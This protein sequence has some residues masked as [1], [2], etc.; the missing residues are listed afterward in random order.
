MRIRLALLVALASIVPAG[1]GAHHFAPIQPGS[2]MVE[3]AGCTMN[4]LF[5]DDAGNQY[6]GTA[7]HCVGFSSGVDVELSGTGKIGSVAWVARHPA[8][9]ALVRIDPSMYGLVNP[10][11]RYWGGPTGLAVYAEIAPGTAVYQYGHG[12]LLGSNEISRARAGTVTVPTAC[13]Y[14]A[15]L[16]VL[17]G[18]SG[19]PTMIGDGRALG[20]ATHIPG[21]FLHS[22]T[23]VECA[24]AQ[25]AAQGL[26]L[27]LR[28]APLADAVARELDRVDHL[29]P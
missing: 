12:L 17:F 16:P 3:P 23:R 18:D 8:D 21:L 4:F 14:H 1:A 27:T 20:V 15:N 29:T 22:G 5:A 25:A 24:L 7:G 28:T 9:F 26:R 19:S 2:R 13:R 10:A 11:M 6:I